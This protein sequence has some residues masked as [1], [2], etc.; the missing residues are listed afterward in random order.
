[1]SFDLKYLEVPK[2]D[3]PIVVA[4]LPGIAHVGKLA[5][6]YLVDEIKAK[7]FAEL[8]TDYFPGWAI[9]EGGK[10]E[11]LKVDFYAGKPEGL[12]HDLVIITSEAQA[13]SP[14][15]QYKLS[16]RIL[17]IMIKHG[18]GTVATMAAYLTPRAGVSEVVGA[19]TDAEMAELLK[20]HGVRLLEGGVI[21]G[22]N[23]LLPAL[24]GGRGLK[25][26]C[27][28][29]TTAGGIVD[30]SASEAVLLALMDVLG[31][32]VDLSRIRD[33]ATRVPRFNPPELRLPGVEEEE[34]SYIR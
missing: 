1:M 30:V 2:L 16:A 12:D 11:G 6:D 10:I 17:D 27:L 19:A 8:Y 24:A 18:T 3:R 21:V 22:M 34:L 25:G 31:F 9:R 14:F 26:F 28:L 32:D 5:A 33:F 23:G 29:G 7:K 15:G 4:G 13:V 20:E